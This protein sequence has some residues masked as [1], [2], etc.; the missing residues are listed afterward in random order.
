MKINIRRDKIFYPKE[1]NGK[2]GFTNEKKEWVIM[3]QFDD[4]DVFRE[5][6][7]WVKSNHKW[8]LINTDGEF[9]IKPR[10]DDAREFNQ[11]Y[12]N[13]KI[14]NKW[15]VIDKKGNSIFK[16]Q[17]DIIRTIK[18]GFST[19]VCNNMSGF[20]DYEHNTAIGPIYEEV[21][22]FSEGF[23]AVKINGL[24]GFINREGKIVIEPQFFSVKTDFTKGVDG[25]FAFVVKLGAEKDENGDFILVEGEINKEGKELS[26]WFPIDWGDNDRWSYEDDP[27]DRTGVRTSWGY[28]NKEGK[29]AI[30][31]KF[32]FAES[33]VDN[34]AIVRIDNKYGVIEKNGTYIVEPEYSDI[35]RYKDSSHIVFKK[36]DKE[37]HTDYKLNII[38]DPSNDDELS[39]IDSILNNERKETI[40]SQKQN[41]IATF[42]ST[43]SWNNYKI[44]MNGCKSAVTDK[45]GNVILKDNYEAYGH[46]ISINEG[47]VRTQKGDNFGFIDCKKLEYLE[48]VF[49]YVRD[50]SEGLAA[51]RIEENKDSYP[52]ID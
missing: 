7:C 21:H 17:F 2:K 49:D 46:I 37:I 25:A 16:P 41:S 24:W 50:F 32:Q 14:G 45:D 52:K 10:F 20:I 34:I 47:M 5:E 13:I 42:Q 11:G 29:W 44:I 33:F 28:I 6:V 3:P 27:W 19:V 26:E 43:K 15:G 36:K 1:V 9:L 35:I 18:N 8:G 23:A 39:W 48:P 22:D 4:V 40:V 31:P 51:V 12:A 30:K 38:D